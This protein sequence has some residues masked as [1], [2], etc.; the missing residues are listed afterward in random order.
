M[1]DIFTL[2]LLLPF[3]LLKVVDFG[4]CK[5]WDFNKELNEMKSFLATNE[6]GKEAVRLRESSQS[7]HSFKETVKI[8]YNCAL[9]LKVKQTQEEDYVTA[10]AGERQ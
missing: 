2:I 5:E 4:K 3:L 10:M 7:V 8:N 9:Y 1:G 6:E